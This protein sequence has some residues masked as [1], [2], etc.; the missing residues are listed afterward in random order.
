MIYVETLIVEFN[1]AS[2]FSGRHG[3]QNFCME[4]VISVV[5][6]EE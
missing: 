3:N 6:D 4:N 2:R 5:L 1:S